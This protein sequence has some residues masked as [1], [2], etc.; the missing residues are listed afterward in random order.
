LR[1]CTTNNDWFDNLVAEDEARLAAEKAALI[2]YH[3]QLGLAGEV[4]TIENLTCVNL[5]K[6]KYEYWCFVGTEQACLDAQLVLKH[7]W[8][9]S[10][11]FVTP[12][13]KNGEKFKLTVKP[14]V[15]TGYVEVSGYIQKIRKAA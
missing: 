13:S 11:C 2:E 15:L 10:D 9:V 7:E 8:L 3:K 5:D 4:L 6:P 14:R 12:L 1:A